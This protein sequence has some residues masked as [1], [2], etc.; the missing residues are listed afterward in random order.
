MAENGPF[1]LLHGHQGH[2]LARSPRPA[3]SIDLRAEAEQFVE[4]VRRGE[5]RLDPGVI[6]I[7]AA[8]Q[9]D[10]PG[11]GV[12]QG[13]KVFRGAGDNA[14]ERFA[15]SP[16]LA[17]HRVGD[18]DDLFHGLVEAVID[19]PA[20]CQLVPET[21]HPPAWRCRFVVRFHVFS[22]RV[23]VSRASVR[24]AYLESVSACG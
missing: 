10:R 23:K 5:Q 21:A 14:A 12:Q 7:P 11:Q 1:V 17:D 16:C 15:V 8:I 4:F 6:V 9:G 22:R 3:N 24:V 20:R 13:A 2:H 18:L 19:R